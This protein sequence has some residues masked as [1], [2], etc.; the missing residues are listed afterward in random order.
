MAANV[1]DAVLIDRATE[2]LNLSSMQDG[3][4][5]GDV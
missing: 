2:I 5:D 1:R 4:T 3:R